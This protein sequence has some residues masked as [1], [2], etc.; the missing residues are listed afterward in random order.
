METFVSLGPKP[1]HYSGSTRERNIVT[2]AL[3]WLCSIRKNFLFLQHTQASF[4]V[5]WTS[6]ICQTDDSQFYSF[7]RLLPLMDTSPG[8]PN[9][10]LTQ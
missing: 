2:K 4:H 10:I 5:S 1:S 9:G 3:L 7:S 8:Q 6:V